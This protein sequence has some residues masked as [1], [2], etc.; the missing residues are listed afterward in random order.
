MAKKPE[1]LVKGVIKLISLPEIFIRVNQVMEDKN[2]NAKQLGDVISHDPS[3]TARILRIVNSSYYALVV[4]IEVV[5]R[6]ISVIGEDDLRNLVLATSAVDSF[7]RIPN[8]LVDI[9]LFWRHSVHTGIIARLIS[10]QCNVLHGERLFVAGLLHDIGKL[11]LFFEEPELSQKVLL[12]AAETDGVT[13]HA[14][15]DIIGFTHADVGAALIKTWQLSDTLS[16]AISYHHEPLLARKHPLETSIVHIAN[17]VVNA[18]EPGMDVNEHLLDD[19]PE[20]EPETLKITGF[21]LKKL[22]QIM[23]K[24]WEQAAEVLDIICPKI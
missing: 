14:E 11:I 19:Y 22:P 12:R 7:K 6:A 8:E 9:D 1:D 23:D 20:F 24:A 17:C 10:K 5:S 18:L 3:L 21:K 4:K 15:K 2:H 13:Y 16:D